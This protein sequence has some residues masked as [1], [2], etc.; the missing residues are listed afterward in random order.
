MY[1]MFEGMCVLNI[2]YFLDHFMFTL[3]YDDICATNR[4]CLLNKMLCICNND[5]ILNVV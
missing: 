2:H 4:P 5:W 3:N 1:C